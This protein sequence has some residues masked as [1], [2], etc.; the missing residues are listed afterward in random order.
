[1]HI[2]GWKIRFMR[3]FCQYERALIGIRR[4]YRTFI[5]CCSLQWFPLGPP[6][7]MSS[8]ILVTLCR[9]FQATQQLQ[10]N[11]KMMEIPGVTIFL[12]ALFHASCIFN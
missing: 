9:Q 11:N 4:L 6:C 7:L 10:N 12:A 1:M 8:V 3:T 5:T 2:K